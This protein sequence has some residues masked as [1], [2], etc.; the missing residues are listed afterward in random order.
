MIIRLTM[1][2]SEQIYRNPED[3]NKAQIA[4]RPLEI[5]DWINIPHYSRVDASRVDQVN[6][7]I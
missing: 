6:L 2:R 5:G 3:E 4:S 1:V 7:C